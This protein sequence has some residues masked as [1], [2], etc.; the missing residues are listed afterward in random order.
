MKKQI[1]IMVYENS[2]LYSLP[3]RLEDFITLANRW[4]NSVPREHR[5]GIQIA[6]DNI[7]EGDSCCSVEICVFYFRDETDEEEKKRL[8]DEANRKYYVRQRKL[9]EYLKLK[10]EFGGENK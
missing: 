10:E 8:A 5:G 4:R 9:A 3:E 2:N 7:Y 6:F 1:K